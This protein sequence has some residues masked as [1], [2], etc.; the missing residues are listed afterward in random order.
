MAEIKSGYRLTFKVYELTKGNK[1]IRL[2]HKLKLCRL[3][4]FGIQR[5]GSYSKI[6]TVLMKFIKFQFLY[7]YLSFGCKILIKAIWLSRNR[8]IKKIK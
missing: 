7:I 4:Q 1:E 8:K 6:N 2:T 3:A 5:A